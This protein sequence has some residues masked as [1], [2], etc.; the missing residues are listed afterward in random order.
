MSIRITSA[1]YNLLTVARIA[2]ASLA[3]FGGIE[4][5]FKY[6][7]AVAFA[8]AFSIPFAAYTMPLAVA[9]ELG[10]AILVLTNAW[11]RIGAGIL[12][13]WTLFLGVWFHRFWA[14]PAAEWQNM[15]D[16]FFHH[17]VM[18]G[19]FIYLAVFGTGRDG[20]GQS[21]QAD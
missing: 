10:C 7:D 5:I 4:K 21:R 9:L 8:S 16:S 3:A 13:A 12:A 17:L 14:V 20:L 18:T 11:C 15:I 6:A 1:Q 19:G 2:M